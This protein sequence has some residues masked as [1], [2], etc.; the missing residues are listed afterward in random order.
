MRSRLY[1]IYLWLEQR[2]VPG[3]RSSQYQYRDVLDP[4]VTQGCEWLDV[5]CGHSVFGTWMLEEERALTSRAKRV[6]GIDLDLPG[7]KAHRTIKDKALGDL[8]YLPF[9]DRSF[10]IVTANMVVEHLPDPLL[11][12][13][14]IGRVLK[15]G[16]VFVFLTPNRLTISI[17]I[18]SKV[19]AGIKRRL[20]RVLEARAEE[21]VFKTFYRFNTEETVRTLAAQAGFTAEEVHLTLTSALTQMI[22]PVVVF[23][24]LWIRLLRKER[25]RHLKPNLIGVLRRLDA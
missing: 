2:L 22:P 17:R 10:G 9:P 3:L 24:L 18:A 23:E 21:D 13:R 11:I 5:G 7:L 15:P 8:R 16:G 6:V 14:E 20:V 4:H 12:L 19:P 1:E 25:W